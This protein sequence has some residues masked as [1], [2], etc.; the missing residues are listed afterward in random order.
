MTEEVPGFYSFTIFAC[1]GWMNAG[2]ALYQMSIT[3][4]NALQ[5]KMKSIILNI[6][7]QNS[8]LRTVQ[9]FSD[10]CSYLLAICLL[11]QDSITQVSLAQNIYPFSV[12]Q[13]YSFANNLFHSTALR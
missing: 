8:A 10:I 12:L 3:V 6:S 4:F 5:N 1:K 9:L 13:V 11:E 2:R 7:N